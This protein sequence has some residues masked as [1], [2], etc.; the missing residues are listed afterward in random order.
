MVALIE[1]YAIAPHFITECV[2]GIYDSE[3]SIPMEFKENP[4]NSIDDIAVFDGASVYYGLCN[5]IPVEDTDEES[6]FNKET[7]IYYRLQ[8]ITMNSG[9]D[10]FIEHFLE[11]PQVIIIVYCKSIWNGV[12]RQRRRLNSDQ[13]A[14]ISFLSK[15]SMDAYVNESKQSCPLSAWGESSVTTG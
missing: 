2:Q 4:R 11:H 5:C 1:G 6:V 15:S 9:I 7:V 13:Y 14:I 8:E 10:Y 3:E 12:S